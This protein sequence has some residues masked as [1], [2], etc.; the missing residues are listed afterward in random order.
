MFLHCMGQ[1]VQRIAENAA[2]C[3]CQNGVPENRLN[4]FFQSSWCGLESNHF[5]TRAGTGV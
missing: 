1:E 2:I 4:M 3:Q 5:P